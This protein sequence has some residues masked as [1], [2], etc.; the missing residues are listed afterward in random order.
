MSSQPAI[1][2]HHYVPVRDGKAPSGEPAY[3]LQCSC[4][5]RPGDNEPRSLAAAWDAFVAGHVTTNTEEQQLRISPRLDCSECGGTHNHRVVCSRRD[6]MFMEQICA[7]E[8]T[9][10]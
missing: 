9:R 6:A 2:T 3:S 8:A 5:A 4:G 10:S 1:H 7:F